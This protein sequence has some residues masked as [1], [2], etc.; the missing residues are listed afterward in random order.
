MKA[1][2][3]HDSIVSHFG[4]LLPA[5][6]WWE[7]SRILDKQVNYMVKTKELELILL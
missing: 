2:P 6:S 7:E 3:S 4:F 5:Y 1:L